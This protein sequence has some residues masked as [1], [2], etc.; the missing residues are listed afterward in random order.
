[1]SVAAGGRHV[2]SSGGAV[3]T[4]TGVRGSDSGQY[5]CRVVD[6]ATGQVTARR[7]FVV[8]EAGLCVP[9][10]VEMTMRHTF[11]P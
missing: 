5:E 10:C 2:T 1:M 7:L 8:V 4:L 6:A 3:L 9:C 11:D